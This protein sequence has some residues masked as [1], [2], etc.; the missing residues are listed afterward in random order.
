MQSGAVPYDGRM[1]DA[2]SS[3]TPAVDELRRTQAA[4]MQRF[5]VR[6]ALVEGAALIAA[7]VLVFVIEI[8]DPAIGIWVL[9]ALALIGAS[10]LSTVLLSETRRR[11]REL[12]ELGA[13]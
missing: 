8:I 2:D 4:R 10:V 12:A 7:V 11:Q 9:I 3:T 6:F 13:R 5:F 1:S